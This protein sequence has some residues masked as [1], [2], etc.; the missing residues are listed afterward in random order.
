MANSDN[1]LRAGLTPKHIDVEELLAIVSCRA[2]KPEILLPRCIPRGD[3]IEEEYPRR[4]QE[5]VLS[6]LKPAEAA[7]E[8]SG[9][10]KTA[11][12]ETQGPE[13][14]FCG[15]GSAS[16]RAER[17]VCALAKGD[18]VFIPASEQRYTLTGEGVFYRAGVPA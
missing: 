7:R 1:V 4:A 3:F 8:T 12:L 5:F 6:A 13:I 11:V 14:L 16:L 10:P 18:S 15:G 2:A 17:C 9:R